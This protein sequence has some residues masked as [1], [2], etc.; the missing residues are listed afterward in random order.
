MG[1]DEAGDHVLD[2]RGGNPRSGD[3]PRAERIPAELAPGSVFDAE[4]RMPPL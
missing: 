3:E 2:K 4:N 1:V